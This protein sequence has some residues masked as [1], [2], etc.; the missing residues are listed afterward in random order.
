MGT[1]TKDQASQIVQ[2]V[3]QLAKAPVT[4]LADGTDP[5]QAGQRGSRSG[6]GYSSTIELMLCEA[7]SPCSSIRSSQYQSPTRLP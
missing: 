3:L 7:G 5:S 2:K 4:Y 6:E 1:L